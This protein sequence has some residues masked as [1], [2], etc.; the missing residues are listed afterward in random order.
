MPSKNVGKHPLGF[1]TRFSL[2]K[3]KKQRSG[4]KQ[5]IR[6]LKVSRHNVYVNLPK[7]ERGR[8]E[9]ESKCNF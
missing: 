2:G 6:H 1:P 8:L 4:K 7:E 3:K 9:D 5:Q